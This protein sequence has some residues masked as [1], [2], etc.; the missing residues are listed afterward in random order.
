[1]CASEV[2]LELVPKFKFGGIHS[3]LPFETD[4][5][6][7]SVQDS[8]IQLLEGAVFDSEEL[9]LPQF[10]IIL[11]DGIPWDHSV[12]YL[13]DRAT[14]LN[15]VQIKTIVGIARDL[16]GFRRWTE[17]FEVN[18]LEC[19]RRPQSPVRKY[20]RF[21]LH[22]TD[23]APG[24]IKRKLTHLVAFYRW[25]ISSEKIEFS[26]P[27]WTEQ[28][29]T[30]RADSWSNDWATYPT[31]STDVQ[32]VRGVGVNR[33][34]G[35]DG[36][37]L[38][39]GELTPY[40]MEEQKLIVAALVEIGN[41]E[42]MLSFWVA[43]FTGA[44]MQTV[45]TLRAVHFQ[46][47]LEQGEN[48]VVIYAGPWPSRG[49]KT[50]IVKNARL[51]DTKLEARLRIY[52]PYWLYQKIQIYL[53]SERYLK[54]VEASVQFGTDVDSQYVFLTT[55]GLPYYCSKNDPTISRYRYPP[56]GG[57]VHKFIAQQLAP[58]LLRKGF[59]AK[60][61]FHNLRASYGMNIV[62]RHIQNAGKP[63]Y[64]SIGELFAL[65]KS[66]MGHLNLSVT[67]RYLDFDKDF[68]L[69]K[70]LQGEF[71]EVLVKLIESLVAHK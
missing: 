6:I 38:D 36:V 16:C 67:Q 70:T 45:F 5:E 58:K 55:R 50:E 25:L 9:E 22:R 51:V 28:R 40:S 30:Q 26:M 35:Y 57:S 8:R 69:A 54:R 66:R 19:E 49:R 60:F 14:D 59:E 21:L 64:L 15:S 61:K 41:V 71:E 43:L 1:M 10:P 37:I 3:I 33:A 68:E 2:K 42:M 20:R 32:R 27:L 39:G 44:R 34:S 52:F 29:S 17:E 7:T 53:K 12:R 63:G 4:G 13:F 11:V 46:R 31:N 62:R 18:Y 23:Y 65:V 47:K 24:T 56:E 48:E